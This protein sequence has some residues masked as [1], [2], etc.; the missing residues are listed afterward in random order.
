MDLITLA[1][2][3][4]KIKNI[5]HSEECK[6]EPGDSAYEIAVQN[7]FIGTEEEWLNMIYTDPQDR[8][9]TLDEL[10]VNNNNLV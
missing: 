3:Q 4:N 1:M 2:M 8:W 10:L 9:Y 6:G 5:N 7:G